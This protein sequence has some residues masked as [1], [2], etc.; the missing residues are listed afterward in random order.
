MHGFFIDQEEEGQWFLCILME[1]ASKG[2]L[3]QLIESSRKNKE[4]MPEQLIWDI[5]R[6]ITEGLHYLHNN[7]IMHRD[8]KP[9][10][11][12]ITSQGT[13]KIADLG[14]SRN[15]NSQTSTLHISKIGTPLYAAPEM[16]RKQ[17]YDFKIDM[18]ALG[19]LLY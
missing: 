12:L 19:C 4:Y 11:I 3:H 8:I 15:L 13:F 6:Q 2:D 7:S 17:P 10:N 18:W 1:Y 14:I 16:L 5:C 9:H